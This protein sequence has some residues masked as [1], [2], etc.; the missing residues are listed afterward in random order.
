M[1]ITSFVIFYELNF[2]KGFSKVVTILGFT[3][4]KIDVSVERK[5][6]MQLILKLKSLIDF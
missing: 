4:N 6:K 2:N 5:M 1:F 3:N